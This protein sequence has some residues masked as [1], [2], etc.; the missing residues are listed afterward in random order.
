[1]SSLNENEAAYDRYKIRPRILIN[2]DKID[3]TTEFLG[4]KVCYVIL[5]FQHRNED[6]SANSNNQPGLAPIRLQPRRINETRPPRRRARGL[7]R[8]RKIRPLHESVLVLELS[9]RGRCR[10]GDWQSVCDADVST[11][12]SGD[13]RAVARAGGEYVSWMLIFMGCASMLFRGG[14]QGAIPVG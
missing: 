11:A 1:M 4:S 10:S 7:A 8:S 2:V 3:T 13:Y 12:G 6:T 9:T 14:L 5:S